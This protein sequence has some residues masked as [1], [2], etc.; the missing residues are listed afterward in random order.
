MKP[1]LKIIIKD[2]HLRSLS[3]FNPP[4]LDSTA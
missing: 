4:A 1:I 3:P 2:F